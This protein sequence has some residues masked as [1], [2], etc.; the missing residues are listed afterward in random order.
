MEFIKAEEFLKQD[1][2]VQEVL[3]EWWKNNINQCDLIYNIKFKKI[4]TLID[5][6][7]F[8]SDFKRNLILES[9]N[10]PL[11]TEG[12]LRMFIQDKTKDKYDILYSF[13]LKKYISFYKY[14]ENENKATYEVENH[15]LLKAYWEVAVKVASECL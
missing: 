5:A 2:E 8:N 3:I 6:D 14:T 1:K 13:G 11:W 4:R 15:D 7:M 12:Q 10:I 9:S